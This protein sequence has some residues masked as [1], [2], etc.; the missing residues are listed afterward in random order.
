MKDTVRLSRP[1]KPA[2][3]ETVR[4]EMPPSKYSEVERARQ[5]EWLRKQ[6]PPEEPPPTK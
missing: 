3:K 1:S 2:T 5:Q 4:L 6:K